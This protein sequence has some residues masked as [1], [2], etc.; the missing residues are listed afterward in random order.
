MKCD[1]LGH[2]FIITLPAA[3][4]LQDALC[5]DAC[6]SLLPRSWG[7][8]ASVQRLCPHP[9]MGQEAAPLHFPFGSS[10]ICCHNGNPR[11][12][13][14][15]AYG[16]MGLLLT[17]DSRSEVYRSRFL[18]AVL[19]SVCPEGQAAVILGRPC[20]W[21]CLVCHRRLQDSNRQGRG[22]RSVRTSAT[23]NWTTQRS[24]FP[25]RAPDHLFQRFGES[26]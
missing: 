10:E 6:T 3:C 5:L 19:I 18:Y 14:T 16:D 4:A 2:V 23:G 13:K 1:F 25:R 17:P 20:E 8:G 26:V 9:C 7:T 21:P 12:N 24:K 11:R 22:T 15:S